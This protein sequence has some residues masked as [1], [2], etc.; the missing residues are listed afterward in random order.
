VAVSGFIT[1]EGVRWGNV[2]S[3]GTIILL[4]VIAFTLVAQ[5]YLVRGMTAGAVKG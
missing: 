1:E 2:G 3:G 5:K 4:P